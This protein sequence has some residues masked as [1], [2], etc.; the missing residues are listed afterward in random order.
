M[1]CAGPFLHETND[2][3]AVVIRLH[4]I[5]E[6]RVASQVSTLERCDLQSLATKL[7]GVKL[8]VVSGA[9]NANVTQGDLSLLLSF[10]V[11]DRCVCIFFGV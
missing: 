11:S 5:D 9:A 4:A 2:G 10:Q 8:S 6:I 3:S 7:I 1:S